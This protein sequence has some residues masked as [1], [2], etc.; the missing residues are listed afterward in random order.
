L[1]INFLDFLLFVCELDD[2]Y[3]LPFKTYV[4]PS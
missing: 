1:A 3:I 4:R 2:I